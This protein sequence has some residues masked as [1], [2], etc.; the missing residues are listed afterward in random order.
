VNTTA[1]QESAARV[2][3]ATPASN[4]WIWALVAI[5]VAEGIALLVIDTALGYSAEQMLA[6][7]TIT[8]IVIAFTFAPM[9]G[10]ILSRYRHH[11]V[12]WIMMWIGITAPLQVLLVALAELISPGVPLTEASWPIA[13]M[14]WIAEWVWVIAIFPLFLLLPLFFPDDRLPSRHWRP[15]LWACVG[16]I[17]AVGATFA[18]AASPRSPGRSIGDGL[19]SEIPASVESLTGILIGLMVILGI[20]VVASVVVR[21]RRSRGK[22]R[23]QLE[24]LLLAVTFVVPAFLFL[25]TLQL[26]EQGQSQNSLVYLGFSLAVVPLPLAMGV[27]IVRHR[28]F[29]I[30]VVVSRS[31]VYAGLAGFI[32][33]VYVGVVVGVGRLVGAGDEP[34]LL[35]QVA[36]TAFV[37]VLFQP[38]R[39]ALQRWAN[40]LIFGQRS[41]PYEVL[42]EFS[43][44]AT[45]SSDDSAL[46]SVAR[47]L[48]EGTGADPAT[49]WLRIGS[50]LQPVA[51]HPGPPGDTV[52]AL[53]DEVLSSLPGR[54][55]VP[56]EQGGDLL[57]VLTIDKPR[58]DGIGE[59][60]VDLTERL[61]AGVGVLLRNLRLTAEL[62][63]RLEELSHSRQ[64]IVSAQDDARRRMERDIHDGAQQQLVALKIK[65]GLARTLADRAGASQTSG[66]LEQLAADADGA[67]ETLRELARGIYPPLLEAE[68]LAVA[69][70]SQ[71]KKAPLPVTVY[72]NGVRRYEPGAEA[73]VY[74]CILEAL[75]NV[76]KYAEATSAHIRIDDHDD[77]LAFTVEDNGSG[78]DTGSVNGGSGLTGMAD[79]LDT[80]GGRLEVTSRPGHGTVVT[81]SVPT[82]DG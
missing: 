28:L 50:R 33:M 11:R 39:R 20:G 21:Y 5:A 18:F 53:D 57:G 32:T 3:P 40:R 4:W 56:V 73:A 66:L 6:R 17:L 54:L 64:R 26:V 46:D 61:A 47:L 68:G 22:T 1:L 76:T 19:V 31:L 37:A 72:A 8:N 67:V 36:A 16:V 34:S 69:V 41:T 12:G 35:F 10:L 42:A 65:L 77:H 30:D 9:A 2:E 25:L 81:G 7:Y 48:A 49:V 27:A 63:E 71:A 43:R 78:F 44:Q 79:R 14:W 29:D 51:A 70:D 24:W 62:Q 45:R 75:N 60:D 80:L 59:G 23:Q 38:V 55:A 52:L 82:G 15:L 74:F 13:A 58:S